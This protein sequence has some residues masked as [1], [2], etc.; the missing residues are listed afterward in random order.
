MALALVTALKIGSVFS[1]KMKRAQDRKAVL[2][3]GIQ[4]KRMLFE[5]LE[6]GSA[7]AAIAPALDGMDKAVRIGR[8]ERADRDAMISEFRVVGIKIAHGASKSARCSRAKRSRC[9]DI[10][11]QIG[12][13]Q[14]RTGRKQERS[15]CKG[16]V[17]AMQG[18]PNSDWAEA[19]SHRAQARAL[20]MQGY[21][22]SDWAESRS[23][24]AEE[25]ISH[26]V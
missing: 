22:N 16:K 15:R 19:K 10:R 21:P 12:W 17:L 6:H 7:S 9:K 18:Y 4:K 1:V 3:N 2:D 13:K 8:K 5:A 25:A 23:V 20:E 26:R 24:G 11:I 14:N